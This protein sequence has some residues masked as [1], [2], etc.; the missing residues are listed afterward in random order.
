MNNSDST[1]VKKPVVTF[2][3]IPLDD[4]PPMP[5]FPEAPAPVIEPEV[6]ADITVV[7][8]QFK[9]GGK[10]YF[11]DPGN[12]TVNAGD[13][14]IIDTARGPEYG[15][16]AEGNHPVPAENVVQPLRPV[17][18]VATDHDKRIRQEFKDREPAAFDTCQQKILEHK[19][20]MKL[21]SAEYSFDGSKILFYFTAD[22]RVDFRDLVKDLAAVF[23][24]RIE[25][26]QIGVRDEAKIMGGLGI[27]G[28]PFCCKQFLDDFQPVSIKMAKTQNLSLNPTKISGT[29]GR[30]MC[31]LKYEQDTYEALLKAAP[32]QDSLVNTCDGVGT[33]TEVNLLK[34]SVKV[35][36]E[37]DPSSVKCY[38]NCDICVLRN[39]KGKKND[40]PIPENLPPLPKPKEK[41]PEAE[42]IT[43]FDESILGIYTSETPAEPAVRP[44][45]VERTDRTER[46]DCPERKK[47]QR[48]EQRREGQAER[49]PR[50][51]RGEKSRGKDSQ[52]PQKAQEKK[53]VPAPKAQ[54]PA[55]NKEGGEHTGHK[56]N[57]RRHYRPR[58]SNQGG[59]KQS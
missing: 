53:S 36:L 47:P 32:K 37:S 21:V 27:C 51:Q 8:I 49:K 15:F 4:E 35:R 16:C 6:P 30:L 46:T 31:C 48:T 52:K 59:E 12:Q 57:R 58:R 23:R 9:K 17:I 14:V 34:E 55:G 7:G 54:A 22:G 56:N 1:Q 26:R 20:D 3:N 28:R 18:R 38:N 11:F 19:L 45:R 24:T 10:I 29:C 33:V 41:K 25:L 42:D 13:E 39:G 44:E 43:M 40:P 2:S 5:V 50:P